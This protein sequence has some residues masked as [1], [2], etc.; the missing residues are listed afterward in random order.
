MVTRVAIKIRRG[1]KRCE[2]EAS[3]G[4]PK[5]AMAPDGLLSRDMMVYF[6]M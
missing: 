4:E 6:D 3:K 5:E 2:R 1:V